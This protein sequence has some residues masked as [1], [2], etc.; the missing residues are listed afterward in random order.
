MVCATLRNSIPKSVVYCQVREAKRSLLD[1]FLTELGKK[2]V[3]LSPPLPPI[4][5]C[6]SIFPALFISKRLIVG[7]IYRHLSLSLHLYIHVNLFYLSISPTVHIFLLRYLFIC[8]NTVH[9]NLSLCLS[10]A[11]YFLAVHPYHDITYSID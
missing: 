9:V 2:E 8:I 10:H 6:P 1:H 4:S 3:S 5:S 11:Q 7:N